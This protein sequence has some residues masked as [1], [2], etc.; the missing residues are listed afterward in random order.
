MILDVCLYSDGRTRKGIFLIGFQYYIHQLDCEKSHKGVK[1]YFEG[2]QK[3]EILLVSK[4]MD[5]IHVH[6]KKICTD[7][8]VHAVE[9]E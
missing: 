4:Y 1:H 9:I 5:L 2:I 7:V 3:I 8:S 6:Y